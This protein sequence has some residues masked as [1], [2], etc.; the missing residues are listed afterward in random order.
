MTFAPGVKLGPYEILSPLGAGG[1]GEVYRARD[2]RLGREVAIKVLP[3]SFARDEDRLLR[4]E[5]EARAASA[6]N[7]P[8]IVTVY[9]VGREGETPFFVC[10]LVEG[11]DLRARLDAGPLA[12]RKALELAAPIASG[13]A[14][15]HEKG[16][17]HR[18]LKP[19]N[20]LITKAGVPKI[21]DFGLAKLTEPAE[22]AQSQMP[23]SDGHRTSAGVVMGTVSYMSPEQARGAAVD[24]RSDQFSFGSIL[25]EMLAGAPSFQKASSPET[26]AA[27]IRED[28]API[29]EKAPGVPTPL[30]W[31]IERCLAKAPED[32]YVS[33]RDLARDLDAVRQ[34]LSVPASAE[35]RGAPPVPRSRGRSG[36]ARLGLPAAALLLGFAAAFL[37]LR[38][39]AGR[40]WPEF[41][42]LTFR[43]GTV[44]AA[45]FAPDGQTVVYSAQW[46][47][48]PAALFTV[49]PA[50]AESAPI[51]ADDAALLAVSSSEELAV[52]LH[53]HLWAGQLHG[54]LARLPLGGGAPR[55]VMENVAIADWSP[56]GSTLAVGR[57]FS[58]VRWRIEYPPG[59]SFYET[60][61]GSGG[62]LGLR[63]SPDGKTFAV[64]L[65]GVPG[66]PHT[67]ARIDSAGKMRTLVEGASIGR[68][69][70]WSA[71][72][73]E[74]WYSA[75]DAGGSSGLWAVGDTGK[76][77]LALR[78]AG[79]LD[80][81]D[82][83]RSGAILVTVAHPQNS[84]MALAPGDPLERDLAWLEGTSVIDV[85][86]DG[87][88][89][90]LNE[91]GTGGGPAGAFY[92]RKNDG[93][94]AVRLGEG[95]AFALSP[96][97][98]WVVAHPP[99]LPNHLV[100]VPTGPGEA[101]TVPLPME[102]GQAWFVP[103]G[104]LLVSGVLPGGQTKLFTVDLGGKGYR[105]VAPD[106]WDTFIGEMPLSPD[107]KWV[108]AQAGEQG[109]VDLRLF[110]IDGGAPKAVPGFEPDDVT[111]RWADDGRSLFVFKRDQLPAR[112][113]RLD[114]ET[115][116]RKP[117][118]EL[119]P[120]DTA[121]VS[122]IATLVLT[123][124]G[125]SYAYNVRRDLS[126]LYL[127]RG[128]K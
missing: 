112:V 43:R 124:D 2:T 80:L 118:L 109:R 27:I 26:L 40:E 49:R 62:I 3:E 97:G 19:E 117:W 108:A 72:G 32:R 89:F 22:G 65:G 57:L 81:Q 113:V 86:A 71:N 126:D 78:H 120:A 15:A 92:L 25:Y 39:P 127:V 24:Y 7:D 91:R 75:D 122:R 37:A 13:L 104:R 21:S 11:S 96:D 58:G 33:T 105:S 100:L 66:L 93:S 115:G 48:A 46:E 14:A 6:L 99:N 63:F 12:A 68:N 61:R 82:V 31:I 110:P 73:K 79:S 29:A 74:I 47:G 95:L 51:A 114:V 34:H 76:P 102:G 107:G 41:R 50:A 111:A 88:T 106:G 16:I 128:L 121:G 123:P 94:P 35:T 54:T 52:K 8:H 53:S 20:V 1:M 30:A 119:M 17:V 28:P 69:V 4:F 77:R 9:D 90:L 56:D 125:K 55:E 10:E 83:S 67:I 45:R 84:V 87:R 101:R 59:K 64:C 42:R 5:R 18:D 103:G 38:R 98:K 36:I 85:S 70:A 44:T 116:E 60:S 23:T